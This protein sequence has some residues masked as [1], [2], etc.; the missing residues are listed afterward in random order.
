VTVRGALLLLLC[1]LASMWWIIFILLCYFVIFICYLLEAHSF[2]MRK[3]EC[4]WRG[5]TWR[6]I[7]RGGSN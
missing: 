4:I 2:R 7:G 1:Y 3:S 6:I 5:G